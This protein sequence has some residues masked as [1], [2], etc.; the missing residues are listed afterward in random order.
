VLTPGRYQ[1]QYREIVTGQV[2]GCILKKAQLTLTVLLTDSVKNLSDKF[3]A[4]FL[5]HAC[6]FYLG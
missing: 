5:F 1:L 2:A 6:S 3:C 4:P